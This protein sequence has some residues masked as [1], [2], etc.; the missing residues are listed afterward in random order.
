MYLINWRT[1]L[2]KSSAWSVLSECYPC[3]VKACC[4]CWTSL[5]FSEA[6]TSPLLEKASS[7]TMAPPSIRFWVYWTTH[8][9][10]IEVVSSNQCAAITS[11]TVLTHRLCCQ[12]QNCR[13]VDI[14]SDF[15]L[16]ASNFYP[17][18]PLPQ[19]KVVYQGSALVNVP[20]FLLSLFSLSKSTSSDIRNTT[21]QENYISRH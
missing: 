7:T 9:S 16:L 19:C 3:A 20:V 2:Y 5:Q 17:P 6:S 21:R 14:N 10:Y 15:S 12:A 11:V 18:Y 8:T 13:S 1:K 4:N